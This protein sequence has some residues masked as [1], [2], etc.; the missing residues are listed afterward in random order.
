[1]GGAFST[2]ATEQT[3]YNCHWKTFR[4]TAI[5]EDARRVVPVRAMIAKYD[6]EVRLHSFLTSY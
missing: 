4:V 2:C 3:E 1:M 6:V 5:V